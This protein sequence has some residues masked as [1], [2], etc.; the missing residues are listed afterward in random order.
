[1]T[2]IK[3][4]ADLSEEHKTIALNFAG[5]TLKQ[6]LAEGAFIGLPKPL[7]DHEIL[8]TTVIAA[9]DAWYTIENGQLQIH[10]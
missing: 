10:F 2:I 3:T 7:N 8:E 4:F 6:H 1:M 5:M 9:N